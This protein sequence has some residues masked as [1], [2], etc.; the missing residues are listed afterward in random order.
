MKKYSKFL[1]ILLAVAMVLPGMAGIAEAAPEDAVVR[2][3]GDTRVGTAVDASKN[4]AYPDGAESVVLAGRN[5]TVDALT[6]SILA[7]AKD[8]PILLTLGNKLSEETEAELERLNPENIFILGGESAI[9]KSV[10][11]TLE[12]DYNVKRVAGDN[13]E[14]TAL[15]VAEEVG[16]QT[17]HVFLALGMPVVE[18]DSLADALAVGPA[19][20]NEDIPVLL[21]R[22]GRLADTTKDAL[23]ELEVEKITIVGGK[24]AITEDTKED[25]EE[26]G[27]EIVDRLAGDRRE[28]TALAIAEEFF[29]DSDK[30]VIANGRKDADA[31]VGGYLGAMK[32]APMLLTENYTDR[33]R[34]DVKEYLEENVDKAWVFGGP[35]VI[36]EDVFAMIE[37]AVTGEEEELVVESVSAI[38]ATSV[39]VEIAELA[40]DLVDAN[41][42]VKD[43]AGNVVATTAKDLN[44][45]S[46]EATFDFESPLTVNPTSQWTVN[47][48]AYEVSEFGIVDVESLTR[49]GKYIEVKFNS[50]LD[51]LDAS[52][53]KVRDKVSL[54]AYGVEEVKLSSDK[55]SAQVTLLGDDS[56]QDILRAARVYTLS[57]TQDGEVYSGEFE[58]PAVVEESYVTEIDAA[59]RTITLGG[60]TLNVPAD[61]AFDFEEAIGRE[62]TVWYDKDE[63]VT[64][65]NYSEQTVK[66]DA[67]EFERRDGNLYA[68]L[69][70]ED[71]E[72]RVD[73]NN[74]FLELTDS[75]YVVAG[76]SDVDYAKVVINNQGRVEAVAAIP[77]LGNEL[78]VESVEGNVVNSYEA[79]FN[80][81]DYTFIKDGKTTSI[82]DLEA[83]EVVF[84]NTSLKYA[85]VYNNEV[86]GPVEAIYNNEIKVEGEVHDT[87][88][89]KYL[90]DGKF[91]NLDNDG[92]E[93]LEASGENVTLYFDYNGNLE[94]VVGDLAQI[95]TAETPSYL[96]ENA[97]VYDLR[98]EGYVSLEIQDDAGVES[99]LDIEVSSLDS[100]AFGTDKWVD[101]YDK[102][103]TGTE[104]SDYTKANEV[105]KFT[106]DTD[107]SI[108][109]KGDIIVT[110]EDASTEVAGNVLTSGVEGNVA[111]VVRNAEGDITGLVFTTPTPKATATKP[112]VDTIGGLQVKSTTPVFIE[113]FDGTNLDSLESTTWGDLDDSI[114]DIDALDYYTASNGRDV[115][116]IVID[117]DDINGPDETTLLETVVTQINFDKDGYVAN[118]EVYR[119]GEIENL[120]MDEDVTATNGPVAVGDIVDLTINKTTDVVEAIAEQTTEIKSID[121]DDVDAVQIGEGKF[122]TDDGTV[123]RIPAAGVSVYEIIENTDGSKDVEVRD[124]A[125]LANLEANN[126]LSISR[127]ENSA[128][129]ADTV[130][131]TKNTE[132]AGGGTT[133][134]STG[135]TY[136]VTDYNTAFDKLTLEDVEGNTIEFILDSSKTIKDTDDTLLTAAEADVW[137]TGSSNWA[138]T[139]VLVEV[140]GDTI[141]F[142]SEIAAVPAV[143]TA[144]DGTVISG[145]NEDVAF[146]KNLD[147]TT[148]AAIKTAVEDAAGGTGTL[149]ATWS[150]DKTLNLAAATGDVTWAADV[151]ADI[152]DQAGNTVSDVT[153]IDVP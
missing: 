111:E 52:E 113:T 59:E 13:R 105:E 127:L 70:T 38:T 73:D 66:Y 40:E 110:Y 9:G 45:G 22:P 138:T 20:A 3:Y 35:T 120:T 86:T 64:R 62:M 128:A 100:V 114:V 109:T 57:I 101:G 33:F 148:K 83:G 122:T 48:V 107:G 16:V 56:E 44:A 93:A 27:Y 118:L 63:N 75:G 69:I 49:T 30:A 129:Y 15:A 8:A 106:L 87:L 147:A 28:D 117:K 98:A 39:T 18:G 131:I 81:K 115:S 29:A 146:S 5:G 133:T 14:G 53:V 23:K 34:D 90:K 123:Y 46:T 102:T 4:V 94:L 41:V 144:G 50:P 112:T 21:A 132:A 150:D 32:D 68:T 84:Y 153:V 65:V 42:V 1:A 149:T 31:L 124:L 11:E 61:M 17:E 71:K 88:G 99:D 91:E 37:K 103:T 108:T 121:A 82:S 151:L 142:N 92:L 145:T 77:T 137:I 43:A 25:L 36:N 19:S 141:K 72:Y 26:E 54:K 74:W 104:V 58:L 119:N 135:T 134:P 79:D 60:R 47:G 140:S 55:M 139:D 89:A 24:S 95:E 143:T 80:F 51:S 12:A 96:T 126:E 85:V 152:T 76:T 6:G 7:D 67:V 10:E 2:V 97:K 136:A 116:Y 78:L 125:D 130:V